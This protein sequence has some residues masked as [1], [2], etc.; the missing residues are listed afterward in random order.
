MEASKS[1]P[2]VF[3]NIIGL[4]E[5]DKSRNGWN[6]SRSPNGKLSLSITHFPAKKDEC[7][8]VNQRRSLSSLE[9]QEQ[10]TTASGHQIPPSKKRKKT[11]AQKRR[12]RKRY[13][14][15][16]EKKKAGT[17]SLHVTEIV[18]PKQ[19]AD[20]MVLDTVSCGTIYKVQD[21]VETAVPP[22]ERCEMQQDHMP[23]QPLH[24]SPLDPLSDTDTSVTSSDSELDFDR[25]CI[26]DQEF[27]ANCMRQPPE[28]TLKRCTRCLLSYYCSVQCQRA[29]WQ[30]HELACSVVSSQRMAALKT[31]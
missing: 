31:F 23:Q 18:T 9:S 19:T 4:L 11:P 6:L 24:E 29:N 22:Q 5:A 17:E 20:P 3:L 1:L 2:D 13:Q 12:A 15:W 25:D 30:D 21:P 8:S 26:N 28:C 10:D 14:K 7:G 16:L 27:C